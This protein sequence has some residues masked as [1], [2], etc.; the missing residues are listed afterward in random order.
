MTVPSGPA[1]D[2]AGGPTPSYGVHVRNDD[3]PGVIGTV[4]T[5]LGA[6]GI[7]IDNMD[8]GRAPS[9]HSAMMVI[10]IGQHP[11]AEVVE[12]LRAADGVTSVDIIDLEG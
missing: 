6:A 8:V 10:D 4:G 11:P 2:S 3:R 7:N 5:I 12:A 9:G 1:R